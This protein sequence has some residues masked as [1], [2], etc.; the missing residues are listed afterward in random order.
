MK[1]L[2]SLVGLFV[3]SALVLTGCGGG[4]KLVCTISEEGEN[5]TQKGEVTAAIKDGKV[6]SIS[7]N[8][9]FATEEEATQYMQILKLAEAFM[10]EDVKIGAKQS[11][12]KITIDDMSAILENTN[13]NE[14]EV[15]IIG[16]SKEDFK[17]RLE[18]QG[19][20]CK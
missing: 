16:M 2:F 1:K 6:D 7:A 4:E 20:S 5:G 10:G 13:D 8:M 15:K 17:A 14:N 18:E 11:G 9:E 3:F 12:K 19:Y